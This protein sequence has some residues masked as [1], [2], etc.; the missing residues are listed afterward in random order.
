MTLTSFPYRN[1][2]VGESELDVPIKTPEVRLYMVN[3]SKNPGDNIFWSQGTCVTALSLTRLHA[4][5]WYT[6]SFYF[7]TT[8][9]LLNYV[10]LL[11]PFNMFIFPYVHSFR[12]M[13]QE[14]IGHADNYLL[15]GRILRSGGVLIKRRLVPS[16]RLD[17]LHLSGQL[18]H[19]TQLTPFCTD[20]T[21]TKIRSSYRR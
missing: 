7:I 4:W 13:W 14:Y 1:L 19:P 16:I 9:H 17:V 6:T 20:Q 18:L 3:H 2:G 8:D 21:I 5:W 15:G 11:F 12:I 10:S